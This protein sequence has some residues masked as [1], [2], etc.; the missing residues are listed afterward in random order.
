MSSSETEFSITKDAIAELPLY[1]HEGPVGLVDSE[2]KLHEALDDLNQENIIGMDTETRPAFKKG[3][4]YP[5]SILQLATANKSWVIQVQK[6]EF[7][8]GLNDILINPKIFKVGVALGFDAKRLKEVYDIDCEGIV[9]LARPASEI[10]YT[11]LGMRNLTA[12]LMGC[13]ISKKEQLSKWNADV[14]S[15][16][17]IRYAATDAFISRELYFRLG[18][19]AK[20][21]GKTV[22]LLQ[23]ED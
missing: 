4:S 11:Q 17:Q 16:S 8:N 6:L 19:K 1:R 10:G 20:E 14:L 7:P 2:E 18:D 5:P 21:L 22:D 13:R 15:D 9:D 3:Q 12:M 23:V